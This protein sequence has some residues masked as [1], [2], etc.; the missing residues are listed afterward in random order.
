MK[1]NMGTADRFIRIVISIG[2]AFLSTKHIINGAMSIVVL[3]VAIIFLVT[4]LIGNCPL[5]SIFGIKTCSPKK[6][7][8]L[9]S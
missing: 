6:T 2:L 7:S 8:G 9:H 3:A 4:A 1:Q 5:Y